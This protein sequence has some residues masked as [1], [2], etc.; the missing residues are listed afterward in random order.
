MEQAQRCGRAYLSHTASPG[1]ARSWEKH[2][3]WLSRLVRPM[4]VCIS[5]ERLKL[6]AGGKQ[7]FPQGFSW[8]Q[9]WE[10]MGAG[11]VCAGAGQHR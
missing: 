2:S 3:F 10:P 11:C 7:E 9:L 5:H 6:F 8:C 1:A 4:L